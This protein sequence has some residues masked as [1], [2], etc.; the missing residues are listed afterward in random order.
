MIVGFARWGGVLVASF[1]RFL[2]Y[3]VFWLGDFWEGEE[4]S[5]K[6]GREEYIGVV[7]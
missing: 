2:S 7:L 4:I 1:F 6:G 5:G 3:F